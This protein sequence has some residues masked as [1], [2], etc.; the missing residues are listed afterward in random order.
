[1]FE[2]WVSTFG[3]LLAAI[4]PNEQ[5]ASLFIPMVFVFVALFCGVLQPLSQL[6]EFWHFVHYASPFTW[7]IDG[8]FSNALHQTT[9]ICTQPEI[10]IFQP[11]TNT[12][13]GAFIAPFLTYA[14][15]AVY[16]PKSMTDCEYCRY[17]TGDQY[18]GTLDMGWGARWRNFGVMW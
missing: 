8:L 9:V 16:N 2:T 12:T 4:A 13:C 11:P 17:S 14:S 10:N 7:L 18:L 1:M 3:Q 6:P 5:T 15:G